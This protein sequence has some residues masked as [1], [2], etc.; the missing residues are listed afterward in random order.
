M[1]T[2][3][4]PGIHVGFIKSPRHKKEYDRTRIGDKSCLFV[5]VQED[6]EERAW[7]KFVAG[8]EHL[9]TEAFSLD[10]LTCFFSLGFGGPQG[11][12][13]LEGMLTCKAGGCGPRWTPL[14]LLSTHCPHVNACGNTAF[15]EELQR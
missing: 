5:A 13:C 6:P 8:T 10:W 12:P 4:L 15:L 3:I 2:K 14:S 1:R 9:A 7:P 11:S